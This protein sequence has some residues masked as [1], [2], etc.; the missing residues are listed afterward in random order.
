MSAP[1]EARLTEVAARVERGAAY[2]TERR[3]RWFWEVDLNQLNLR[4]PK[5]CVLGQLGEG[6][7]PYNDALM[8][9]NLRRV[10]REPGFDRE[11]GFDLRDD[12][13]D[14]DCDERDKV[15]NALHAEWV[16]VILELRAAHP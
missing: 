14:L 9:L 8:T 15:W 7:Y 4:D 6:D 16:R 11:L 2:L 10:D 1:V 13:Y 3:P 5:R 12:E